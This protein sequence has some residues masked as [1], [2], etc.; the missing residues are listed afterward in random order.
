MA[1]HELAEH[2]AGARRRGGSGRLRLLLLAI[3]VVLY[4][5]SVPW[6]R[7]TDAP[8]RVWLG[9]PDWVATALVCYVAAAVLNAWAWW[10][11]DVR[12]PVEDHETAADSP[13]TGP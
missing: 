11:T 1:E 5:V 4:V 7:S 3:I 8:L 10:I 9:L 6:Y 12:D 2:E 13:E